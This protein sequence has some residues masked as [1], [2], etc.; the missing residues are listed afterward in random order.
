MRR[1]YEVTAD[2][3]LT[4]ASSTSSYAGRVCTNFRLF[5][6]VQC[7]NERTNKES[8]NLPPKYYHHPF[9]AA[10]VHQPLP[11]VELDLEVSNVLRFSS[12][13]NR[14][15]WDTSDSELTPNANRVVAVRIG[16]QVVERMVSRVTRCHRRWCN[17]VRISCAL[18]SRTI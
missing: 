13:P 11:T 18:C 10:G 7:Q 9:G 3:V 6:R 16:V 14:A 15:S 17:G 2:E 12:A 4:K 8:A 5:D 1:L